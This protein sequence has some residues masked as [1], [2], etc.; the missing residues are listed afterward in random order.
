MA[1]AHLRKRGQEIPFVLVLLSLFMVGITQQFD[2]GGQT[3]LGPCSPNDDCT[4]RVGRFVLGGLFPVHLPIV[5]EDGVFKKCNNTPAGL[6]NFGFERLEAMR[7][8][9]LDARNRKVLGDIEIGY[10]MRDTCG[11]SNYAL[12]QSLGFLNIEAVSQSDNYNFTVGVVGAASSGISIAVTDLL[13]LFEIPMVSY[14]STS[15]KLSDPTRYPSF[16]RTLPP[17]R[18]QARAM[19][20]IVH[21]LGWRYVHTVFSTGAYGKDGIEAFIRAAENLTID[22][23]A[24]IPLARDATPDAVRDALVSKLVDGSDRFFKRGNLIVMFAHVD[25]AKNVL[26]AVNEN[27]ELKK[28]NFTFIGSDA[29]GDKEEAVK[30]S[31]DV[32]KG[33]LSV[34]PE[35]VKVPPLE[36]H[37]ANLHPDNYNPKQNPWFNQYWEKKFSC[38]LNDT[39]SCKNHSLVNV[40]LDSKVAYVVD[41]VNVFLYALKKMLVTKCEGELE[42]CRELKDCFS[43][44]FCGNEFKTYVQ[45]VLFNATSGGEF[46]FDA[47]GD[48]VKAKYDIKNLQ[49]QGGKIVFEKVGTWQVIGDKSNAGQLNLIGSKLVWINGKTGEENAPVQTCSEECGSGEYKHRVTL[50]DHINEAFNCWTCTPC[51]DPHKYV[52]YEMDQTYGD[53]VQCQE[54]STNNVDNTGCEVLPEQYLEHSD[55]LAIFLMI[56]AV[57]GMT[58]VTLTFAAFYSKWGTP[59]VMASSRE[60]SMVL[61]AGT[62]L[63]FAM[64]F[65]FIGRPSDVTCGIRRFCPVVFLSFIFGA[66]L[67]KTN[68]IS[69]LFNR[70]AN[71]QR[72]PFISPMSQLVFSGIIVLLSC[73][74]AA[75]WLLITPPEA[76]TKTEEPNVKVVRVCDHILNPGILVSWVWV[77]LLIIGC[78]YY[79]FRTRKIPENFRETM[80]ISFAAYAEI[81]IWLAFIPFGFVGLEHEYMM[82]IM[83]LAVMLSALAVWGCLFVPKLYIVV[84]R[85]ERNKRQPTMRRPSRPSLGDVG[86]PGSSI[87]HGSSDDKENGGEF[88]ISLLYSCCHYCTCLGCR[89][90]SKY[91]ARS[92]QQRTFYQCSVDSSNICGVCLWDAGCH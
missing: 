16:Y 8:A 40:T 3:M 69:R 76:I 66:L 83:C 57:I 41:A 88:R 75:V 60:L 55:G 20:D 48:F 33:L 78:T 23:G 79:G 37:V 58:L 15:A 80:F 5:G 39:A 13:H 45:N 24:Q 56:L 62:L 18:F 42:I 11:R 91:A 2:V 67:I 10:D 61:L 14:A 52:S 29:W 25:V 49:V 28:R 81:I 46:N 77:F 43:G 17:D 44:Q 22:V 35:D 1:M 85:P 6:N 31:R 36:Q 12:R 89:G 71:V 32:A 70:Q 38:S 72:P 7:F 4:K 59:V 74:I 73:A 19:A 26:K 51:K 65:V 27:P 84:L 53:C 30:D 9:I 63:C 92:T 50:E 64:P 68:R 21:R 87:Q 90:I 54:D 86:T 34:I 47:A 82:A